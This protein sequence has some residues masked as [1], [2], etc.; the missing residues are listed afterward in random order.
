MIR[1]ADREKCF[2]NDRLILRQSGSRFSAVFPSSE[3][4]G[5]LGSGRLHT[6]PRIANSSGRNSG[7]QAK[8]YHRISASTENSPTRPYARSRSLSPQIS[9]FPMVIAQP[10]QHTPHRT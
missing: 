8:K 3:S 2:L 10:F 6:Q 1:K 9:H 5:S 7:R 4:P